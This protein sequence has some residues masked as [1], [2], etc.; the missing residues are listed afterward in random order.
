MFLRRES[1]YDRDM[2]TSPT[3][4]GDQLKTWRRRRRMSQ[5]DLALEADISTRHLSFVE[6][7]RSRPSRE[8]VLH[9]AER[10]DIPLRERNLLLLAAGY[11][12]QFPERNLDDPSL[13]GA[14]RAIDIVL[15]GHEPFP[16][17]AVDRHWTLVAA[18]R[19]VPIFL[20]GLD[21]RMLESPLNVVRLSL[22]PD[23]M[24]PR[25]VNY[26]E[27]RSHIVD[28]LRHQVEVS[29]DPVLVELLDEVNG[30][31]FPDVDVEEPG[32]DDLGGVAVPLRIRTAQGVL[33]AYSTT[34]I[35]G[36]PMDVT[37]EELAIESFLP[38][39]ATTAKILREYAEVFRDTD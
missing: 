11:A 30:Y 23:G 9:I 20:E 22:H 37:L 29:A 21:E 25:I 10:L 3:P 5:L 28:R 12:P 8:M 1:G 35:F 38:A 26:R 27:W 17:L 19:M 4:F 6:T 7:G 34:T 16:A 39:D 36:T 15:T 13:E 14:R 31:P 2:I 33:S 24:A 32:A 18:N